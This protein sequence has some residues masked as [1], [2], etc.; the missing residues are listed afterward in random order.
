M[1]ELRWREI[2]QGRM[3]P[4]AVVDPVDEVP[5]ASDD[6]VEALVVADIESSYLSVF[7]ELSALPLS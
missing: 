6:L 3:Q 2:A 1:L 7:V 4:A 5:Q